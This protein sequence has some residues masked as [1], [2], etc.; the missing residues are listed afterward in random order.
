MVE[1]CCCDY[2]TVNQL[3]NEV[4]HPLLLD[5]VK[6]PFYRYF[7]VKLWCDCPF[8]PDDGMCRLRDCSVCECP[9]SEFPEPFKK[10]LSQYNPV[11]QEG[12][13]QDAVDRTVDTRAFMGERELEGYGMLY[14]L[15]NCPKYASEESCQEENI[16]YKLVSGLHSSISVHIALDY[17][18]DEATNLWGQ[19]L[20]L[21]Y[22]RVLRCPDRVRN[23]YF[24]FLFV[25]RVVTKA[26]LYLE[27]AEYETGNV[28][29]DLKTKSLVKQLV[30]D[31]KTKAACP[32][33]FDEA[34]L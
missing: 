22:D 21:L 18:I 13:P 23:L 32:V 3:N 27:E 16:L 34:K 28:I 1:D 29:A 30:S 9:E 14:T 31:P 5:L 11:C 17:L 12:K 7:K 2:E 4:L 33:P 26:E 20:T 15:R 19:N 10:P 25:L 6:T 8:W 24:T